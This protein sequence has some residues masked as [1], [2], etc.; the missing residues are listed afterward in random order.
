MNVPSDILEA[1]GTRPA[2]P[3]F[4]ALFQ[5]HYEPIA[6]AIA[7]VIHD[8]GRAEELAVETF[9]KLWR[10][11]NAQGDRAGGW[12]HRT[13]V[14]MAIDELRRN[15]RRARYEPFL[16]WTGRP[17]M[18]DDLFSSAQEQGRVRAVLASIAPRQAELLLLR[19]DGS[20][21]DELAASLE[22]NPTSVGTLLSRAQEA[23]RK[24]YTKRYGER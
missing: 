9:W 17:R 2:A 12:L 19:H 14:R 5:A 6:R 1:A 21:Y 10:N 23:F 3:V 13:A 20:R 24:E 22:I 11:P 15:A 7:R 16:A 18:P 8:N 4:E